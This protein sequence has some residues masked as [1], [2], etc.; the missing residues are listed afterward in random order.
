[1]N[2]GLEVFVSRTQI[3]A[4]L[5][6]AVQFVGAGG[7][8][9]SS[10]GGAGTAAGALGLGTDITQLIADSTTDGT[11]SVATLRDGRGIVTQNTLTTLRADDRGALRVLSGTS[12]WGTGSTSI[13]IVNPAVIV[14]EDTATL[15]LNGTITFSGGLAKAGDG[16]LRLSGS[17][18]NANAS[19]IV[20]NSGT[21]ELNKSGSA[22][23]VAGSLIV[24]DMNGLAG[25][26]SALIRMTGASNNQ[27]AN[28]QAV[29]I[30]RDGRF[31]ISGR[32]ETMAALTMID[33]VLNATT[34]AGVLRFTTGNMTG[35]LIDV[36]AGT[37][38]MAGNLT[39]NTGATPTIAGNVDL[40]N[41][42]RSITV[43][44]N[45]GLK[46]AVISAN[47]SGG[48][49]AGI[50]RL[51]AGI[52]ALSGNNNF[53]GT[54]EVQ[55]F[56][57]VGSTLFQLSFNA[58]TTPTF[59][60]NLT[61]LSEIQSALQALPTIGFN[62]A[63][64]SASGTGFSVTFQNN[65]A[66]TDVSSMRAINAAS[67]V[68]TSFATPTN[69]VYGFRSD[70]GGISLG[71]NSALGQGG[72][73]SASGTQ[74]LADGGDRV[75][76]NSLN[77]SSTLILGGRRDFGGT[78]SITLN[79]VGKLGGFA[80]SATFVVDDPLTGATINTSLSETS[81]G[82][83]INK[84]GVGT[85][86][87]AG[88]NTFTGPVNINA[89]V[90]RAASNLA[91][92]NA[93]DMASTNG[94]VTVLGAAYPYASLELSNDITIS[95][96]RLLLLYP[97]L[98]ASSTTAFTGPLNSFS[99]ALRNV[100]GNNV[101]Q[102]I[103]EARGSTAAD[104]IFIGADAGRLDIVGSYI[105]SG[106]TGSSFVVTTNSSLVKVGE[107]VLRLSGS[108]PN[109]LGNVYVAAGTLELNKSPGVDAIRG[110]VFV[111]DNVGG[112]NAD[113]LRILGAEQIQNGVAVVTVNSSGQ[114]DAS[115]GPQATSE[116]QNIRFGGATSGTFQLS[117]AGATSSAAN[118]ISFLADP[119][120]VQ[121]AL[122][123]ISTIGSGNVIVTGL[124]GNYYVNFA[125]SL[126]NRDVPSLGLDGS[127]LQGV[128][129]TVYGFS[130]QAM[131]VQQGLSLSE[132]Q[133]VLFTAS[134]GN[135]NLSFNGA[136]T[137]ALPFNSSTGAVAAAL[138]ALPT[139]Q[140]V[141]NV[142]V[143]GSVG[144]YQVTFSGSTQGVSQLGFNPA[145]LLGTSGTVKVQTFQ[146]GG[147][148]ANESFNLN[149][150]NSSSGMSLTYR[151]QT[152]TVPPGVPLTATQVRQS[153]ESIVGVGNVNVV[154][155][156]TSGAFGVLAATAG[157]STYYVTLQAAAGGSNQGGVLGPALTTSGPGT[158]TSTSE[159]GNS[160]DI[161]LIAYNATA[162][163]FSLVFNGQSTGNLNAVSATAGDVQAALSSLPSIGA[164]NVFVTGTAGRFVVQFTDQ[165]GGANQPL[166]Q[167]N[168]LSL[169]LN[170]TAPSP[171]VMTLAEGGLMIDLLTPTNSTSAI[172]T[173]TL[174]QGPA[175]AGNIVTGNNLL[176]AGH[177][178]TTGYGGLPVST[179]AASIGGTLS[180]APHAS[181]VVIGVLPSTRVMNVFDSPA[182]NDLILDANIVSAGSQFST[183]VTLNKIGSGRLVLGGSNSNLESLQISAGPVLLTNS[184]ALGVPSLVP[185]QFGT[186]VAQTLISNLVAPSLELSGDISITD[187]QLWIGG[188]GQNQGGSGAFAG[189]LFGA[190]SLRSVSG[191]NALITSPGVAMPLVT[192]FLSTTS[193]GVDAGRLRIDG[194]ISPTSASPVLAKVGAGEL[195]LAGTFSS[196][197]AGSLST[198]DHLAG[199]LV[200]N[201]SGTATVI[202][203]AG[204]SVNFVVGDG[205]TPAQLV[206]GAAAGRD[207][208]SS[209]A[210][211]I[212]TNSGSL[213][214]AN[215]ALANSELQRLAFSAP[216]ATGS[217]ALNF[218]NY[219]TTSLTVD[220]TAGVIQAALEA[221]PTIGGGNVSVTGANGE[222]SILFQNA[223]ANT[224][225]PQIN[226]VSTL[227][228]VV[229]LSPVTQTIVDGFGDESQVL[230]FL[231]AD[232]TGTWN[233][234]FTGITAPAFGFADLITSGDVQGAL[235]S[236]PT[237]GVGNVQVLGGTV[238]A[239]SNANATLLVTFKN[240]LGAID[241]PSITVNENSAGIIVTPINTLSGGG[242]E[243]VSLQFTSGNTNSLYRLSFGGFSTSLLR[244]GI[245][246][247]GDIHAALAA[248]PT[249]GADNVSVNGNT[250][251]T[252]SGSYIVTFKNALGQR[253]VGPF[254]AATAGGSVVTI[255]QTVGAGTA[256]D[257]IGAL[258]LAAGNSSSGGSSLV[259]TG[260]SVLVPAN[261]TVT[262]RG[263]TNS[264]AVILGNIDSSVGRILTTSEGSEGVELLISG[265]LSG[266]GVASFTGGGTLELGGSGRNTN[267]GAVTVNEGT[268]V[269]N[270]SVGSAIM[271]ALTVGDNVG[272][273][274]ADRVIYGSAAN[275]DQIAD[276]LLAGSAAQG[277]SSVTINSS[278]LLNLND[279]N[280]TVVAPITLNVGREFSGDIATGTGTIGILGTLAVGNAAGAVNQVPFTP[281]LAPGAVI[282]GNVALNSPISTTTSNT[283]S[284]II[285]GDYLQG[286][287]LVIAAQI[288]DGGSTAAQSLAI[289]GTGAQVALSANN[290][291]VLLSGNNTFSGSLSVASVATTLT[292]SNS[293][294]GAALIS[295]SGPLPA[296]VVI[297]GNGSISNASSISVTG[298]AN[299]AGG[300]FNAALII[301][302]A[303]INTSNRINDLAAVTLSN[304]AL[305]LVGNAAGTDEWL[306]SLSLTAGTRNLVES[307]TG[308]SGSTHLTFSNASTVLQGSQ[309]SVEFRGIGADLGTTRNQVV[310]NGLMSAVFSPT[311]AIP[312]A[313]VRG[314]GG[315]DAAYYDSVLGV[316]ANPS[317]NEL[318]ATTG[319]ATINDNMVVDHD[320]TLTGN[321]S[322]QSLTIVGGGVE[323]DLGGFNLTVASG[324]VNV[325]GGNS[326]V[327]TIQN[328]T[329]NFSSA[330]GAFTTDSLSA[331]RVDAS[332]D[333][334]V[335]F[336]KQGVGTLVLSGINTFN[337]TATVAAGVMSVASSAALGAT[338]GGVIVLSGAE[339]NLSDNVGLS[340][341]SETLTLS[342]TGI[343]NGGAL[344]MSSGFATVGDIILNSSLATTRVEAGSQLTIN[345]TVAANTLAKYGAG[346]MAFIGSGT[347]TANVNMNEGVLILNKPVGS[348]AANTLVVGDDVG[349]NDSDLVVTRGIQQTVGAMTV[350]STGRVAIESSLFTVRGL[351]SLGLGG[352]RSATIDGT[353]G[354][355]LNN[356]NSVTLLAPSVNSN[357][358]LSLATPPAT[359]STPLTFIGTPTFT[360]VDSPASEELILSGDISSNGIITG[361]AGRMV[362]SGNNRQLN[363]ISAT[364]G[365]VVI[366]ARSN[367]NALGTSGAITIGAFSTLELDTTAGDLTIPNGKTLTA[368]GSGAFLLST[369]AGVIAGIVANPSALGAVRVLGGG[370]ALWGTGS[371]TLSSV[372][373]LLSVESGTT[374]NIP[375]AI[376]T[377]T[378]T[379]TLNKQGTG[380]LNLSAPAAGTFST[381]VTVSEGTLRL[382]GN[383]TGAV[384]TFTIQPNA[385]L[386]VDHS[387]NSTSNMLA[388]T[389]TITM[390]GGTL[391]F[392]GH[393]AATSETVGP[394]ILTANFGAATIRSIS[395]GAGLTISAASLSPAVGTALA[396]ESGTGAALGTTNK[397]LLAN[398]STFTSGVALGSSNALP[399]ATITGNGTYDF[400]KLDNLSI[401]VQAATPDLVNT[402]TGTSSTSYVKLT[403]AGTY[404][405]SG[406]TSIGAL[407]IASQGVTINGAG[408]L[409]IARGGLAASGSA[410]ISGATPLGF[411]STNETDIQ[412]AANSTLTIASDISS[413]QTSGV[414]IAKGG[415]G[416]LVLGGNSSYNGLVVVGSGVVQVDSTYGLGR[417]N[418]G[419]NATTVQPGATLALNT[420]V[421]D[422][423]LILAGA[424]VG[425]TGALLLLNPANATLGNNQTL[426]MFTDPLG[427]TRPV[428]VNTNSNNL[429]L[430]ASVANTVG[431]N[432][433][434]SG[435]LTLSGDQ[436]NSGLGL[437]QVLDGSLVLNKLTATTALGSNVIVAENRSLQVQGFDNQLNSTAVGLL[438]GA[439]LDLNGRAAT[440]TSL[441]LQGA[442]VNT[443]LGLLTVNGNATI[444]PAATSSTIT[445]N[446]T[447]NGVRS[448]AVADGAAEQDLIVSA[449]IIGPGGITK[450]GPGTMVLSALNNYTGLTTLSAGV[451]EI[452]NS[453]AL[454][455]DDGTSA[456]GV[457]FNPATPYQ[458]T[459]RLNGGTAS[460][461]V[462]VGNEYLFNL[463][464]TGVGEQGALVSVNGDNSWAGA[465]YAS[466]VGTGSAALVIDAVI[467]SS[468]STGSFVMSGGITGAQGIGLSKAGSRRLTLSGAEIHTGRVNVL[469]GEL[470][471]N[472]SSISEAP[473]TV[474]T[475]ATLSGT[476]TINGPLLVAGTLRPGSDGTGVFT[477]NNDVTFID[478]ATYE[479]DVNGST[480][481]LTYDQLRIGGIGSAYISTVGT[482]LTGTSTYAAGPS[483]LLKIINVVTAGADIYGAFNNAPAPHGPSVTI[484]ANTFGYN[485]NADASGQY[486]DLELLDVGNSAPVNTLPAP[487][488]A[489]SLLSTA[490]PGI[491]V[492]DL[493]AGTADIRVILSVA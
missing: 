224:N 160:D 489:E 412:V 482:L 492:L 414:A 278:G 318:G 422:E 164:N 74:L 330:R 407:L 269:L 142:T 163:N 319:A 162:G 291:S 284:F 346:T 444:H 36:G 230:Q 19:S 326:V 40:V 406:P 316:R 403:D 249:I 130:D 337:G 410:T 306:R 23:A 112:Q 189:T 371:V 324:V 136:S 391:E 45:P 468:G 268:V 362:L 463:Q 245:S 88:N 392:I 309:A 195:E 82:F 165:L 172:S 486:N 405:V 128:S 354:L 242:N 201:K 188:T 477:V 2:Y 244:F 277:I 213:D 299:Q 144:A 127:L 38:E 6:Y 204:S 104:T 205:R 56:S 156:A 432:K 378:S 58:A 220:A 420:I 192:P 262:T 79:G 465:V 261:I 475:G 99:G 218:A 159:G 167:L 119:S 228:G 290:A 57:T 484:G 18:N 90:L 280:D 464:G 332:V 106:L 390:R 206:Y 229:T 183:G 246:T 256:K 474:S 490:I 64:V 42:V 14:V 400:A 350:T 373:A 251:S 124:P 308:T 396:F 415:S 241:A 126:A 62:N 95:G 369:G 358:V 86:V 198:I 78:N 65:L 149:L 285:S 441:N 225:L 227:T 35:G 30:N 207:Q 480:A 283:R 27:I 267:Y 210:N 39:V 214:M 122:Q 55:S 455:N 467:H 175:G 100:S 344:H 137:S 377:S 121:A 48:V 234:V 434:G 469:E 260:N 54:S 89:G 478:G 426:I 133:Q 177:I 67:G 383:Y 419:N 169:G 21:V 357:Q 134:G 366:T 450:L 152:V 179:P 298:T 5:R 359:I 247:A 161:Q 103:V 158:I 46:D 398:A 320:I 194:V 77:L 460:G 16:T 75:I 399:F 80:S 154:L 431:F 452:T 61:S 221:L 451:L 131:V 146:Q 166:L 132:I 388:D 384:N 439:T 363:A 72:F 481:G 139:I 342:G 216:A 33:G 479:V 26:G 263:N 50:F 69:G 387:S 416:T 180:F 113:K 349:D 296:T 211:L 191:N 325:I 271:G 322:I 66:G 425:G 438:S 1:K 111:G 389:A 476:G 208:M 3:G 181:S 339:L 281:G 453:R 145:A 44:D 275:G 417:N 343:N 258:T 202:A 304:G 22:V 8:L 448:F 270:K 157:S 401:G 196:L 11:V 292:G 334:F 98:S 215:T 336:A 276:Y 129:P 376:G 140:A 487:L 272:G 151:G 174:V 352:D 404:T 4:D 442:T 118:A 49:G 253:D 310:F 115:G 443:G 274:N 105:H 365:T 173:L 462:A 68:S 393:A 120:E 226:V 375:A 313:T 150:P 423:P 53:A 135:F 240:A 408:P 328:G 85:L 148:P 110:S 327:S 372:G 307:T 31:D 493:D 435:A 138:N 116:I 440:V 356:S 348:S 217:Y 353:G 233:L 141:G 250:N 421:S 199:T 364:V 123:S 279:K 402:F 43:A 52:L 59:T 449:T 338:G 259:N 176:V 294:A 303:T 238:G 329:L 265:A 436:A 295:G 454:G 472:G 28:N 9:N 71:S 287:E 473:F 29:T 317:A 385:T 109:Q 92:G 266:P 13:S 25:Q 182:A 437:V 222:F 347:N 223:L 315:L 243:V 17:A 178:T 209:T 108:D 81:S 114:I 170:P 483:D 24:G 459:L 301:D 102:G 273:D 107:G 41:A 300:N 456:A 345:G 231:G 76:N 70:S 37:L 197:P 488:S 10:L 471:M 374:F 370:T 32:N 155:A 34:G 297:A 87:L 413:S 305:R 323:I 367:N 96:K 293:F 368:S 125:N 232:N 94:N 360:L 219:T 282:S 91:L 286:N 264:P 466:N 428:V 457:L 117:F 63:V 458:A 395:T 252:G 47:I 83:P 239:L 314:P 254:V 446:L 411:G 429:T 311:T 200:F 203:T 185:G 20:V 51:G 97:G 331:L 186:T 168:N 394:I 321:T 340:G 341:K 447:S 491:S 235:E 382:R 445:G 289:S 470:Q 418:S 255:T 427:L 153:L 430:L 333:G 361:G 187:E 380:T 73:L 461:R 101:W 335:G 147:A 184:K 381:G 386:S 351:L 60:A 302:N 7:L 288:T 424:G 93:Y 212:L 84:Q 312:Y 12:A 397:F 379:A 433:L 190:G 236:V 143:A 237:I 171:V 15:D 193:I 409:T 485:Y 248:L 257:T 355:S